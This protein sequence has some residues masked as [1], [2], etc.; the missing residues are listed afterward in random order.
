[1]GQDKALLPF[2]G[3]ALADA[4]AQEVMAAAGQAAF[5]GNSAAG[6]PS[7]FPMIP[8][9]YPGKG[10]RGGILTALQDS[11]ACW[12]LIVACDISDVTSSSLR[13]LR[14]AAEARDVDALLPAGPS[15]RL[16]PRCAVYHSRA[17]QPLYPAFSSGQRKILSALDGLAI[18]VQL[19]GEPAPLQNVNTPA[20]WAAYGRG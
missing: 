2:R 5:V 12:N 9:L 10:P 11:A 6:I 20:D 18:A 19:V 17:R 14:D 8:D 13:K 4:I 3:V 16:E 1:M 15:H 7:R